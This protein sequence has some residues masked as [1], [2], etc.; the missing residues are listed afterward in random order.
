MHLT[1]LNV[2]VS[3]IMQ[4][5][6]TINFTLSVDVYVLNDLDAFTN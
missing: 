2:V 1:Y 4:V 6:N 5:Q 3:I